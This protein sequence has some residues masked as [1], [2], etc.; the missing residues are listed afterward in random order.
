VNKMMKVI[1]TGAG[2]QLGRDLVPV[3]EQSCEVFALDRTQLDVTNYDQSDK[4]IHSIQ[5]DVIIH[6]AAYTSV[7]VAESEEDLAYLINAEGTHNMASIAE[8]VGAKMCFIST[9]YVFDGH[10]SVPYTE[11]DRTNPQ[12]VY[13]KSKLAGEQY[14]QASSTKYFIVRT[15]WVYGLHGS[16]FV[17]TMLNLSKEHKE[18]KVVSDQTGSP[19]YTLD[20]AN[21]LCNLIVTDKYGIYHATNSGACSWYE[22]AKAIFELNGTDIQ[23]K[24]CTTAEFPRPASRPKYSVLDHGAIRKNGFEDLRHWREALEHL[25]GQLNARE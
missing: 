5:P 17:K 19:T 13:G 25:L 18:L 11:Y 2:G 12:S 9:D 15:S 22:F 21:F 8:K 24:P 10:S 20:L 16:N 6:C 7:D 14:T 23:V 1:V 4:L 3:L